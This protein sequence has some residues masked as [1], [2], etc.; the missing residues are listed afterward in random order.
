[1]RGRNAPH[2]YTTLYPCWHKSKLVMTTREGYIGIVQA[3]RVYN[4]LP[5]LAQEETSRINE[6]EMSSF[7]RFVLNNLS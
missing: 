6:R 3:P 4:N 2:V 1:M 7:N 5:L